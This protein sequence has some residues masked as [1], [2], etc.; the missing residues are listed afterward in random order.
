[1]NTHAEKTQ[2]NK[3]QT[4]SVA[5]SQKQS[6]GSSTFQFVD[7]RPEAIAQRK[8]QEM[9]NNSLQVKQAAQL[10]VMANNYSAQQQNPIQKKENNTGLPDNLKSGIE[11]L[12]GY[13]MDDVK[14][15]YNSDKPAQLN[16]HAY[17][18]GTDIHLGSNQ[19]KHLPHEAWHV[20]QQKQG[21][22]K[23]TMQMKGKINVNDDYSLE[24]EAD[25]M[26]AK[27]LQFTDNRTKAVSQR[28]TIN[29]SRSNTI[30]RVGE[31]DALNK[32]TGN[33]PRSREM[34]RGNVRASIIDTS[35]KS[36]IWVNVIR[37]DEFKKKLN[38]ALERTY[39]KLYPDKEDFASWYSFNYSSI[40]GLII[41]Y[42]GYGNCGEFA[43]ALKA[44][45]LQDTQDQYIYSAKHDN[46]VPISQYT[47]EEKKLVDSQGDPL[48]FFVTEGDHAFVVTYPNL[49]NFQYQSF[50]HR[51][52]KKV[53]TE[54]RYN[55]NE[56]DMEKVR[57]ADG[58][59]DRNVSKR[60]NLNGI[61]LYGVE[62]AGENKLTDRETEEVYKVSKYL[63]A[64]FHK[65]VEERSKK[66]IEER[67]VQN[68]YDILD[69]NKG[70]L[71]KENNL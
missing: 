61:A 18:Q 36:Q 25:V 39:N 7:N 9:A 28:K 35:G 3:N 23:P 17:A 22:V 43:H 59:L 16:A 69:S 1:M 10:Q 68:S 57:I 60:D 13:S 24:K 56:M 4:V 53:K 50:Y 41:N 38:G 65:S 27:A 66:L 37:S 42:L 34:R 8:L 51:N 45:L 33:S 49:V 44:R 2:E 67:R 58:W 15:H 26:G 46:I 64:I 20:V 32:I 14:V 52:S 12:S 55:V 62:K 71:P 19:E 48:E 70:K 6:E 54:K 47:E 29:G 63:N 40:Y 5:D 21:K 11:N 31:L 30:Q